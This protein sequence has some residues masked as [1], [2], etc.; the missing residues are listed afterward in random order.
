MLFNKKPKVE[1]KRVVWR[2]KFVCL[3]HRDQDCI[4]TMDA[5]KEELYQAGLWEEIE[6]E[7]FIMGVKSRS[8]CTGRTYVRD[9][10]NR[11]FKILDVCTAIESTSYFG[12]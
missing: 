8:R 6:F 11:C 5:E 7:S 2:H 12:C 3:A 10:P 4:P 1:K 9:T